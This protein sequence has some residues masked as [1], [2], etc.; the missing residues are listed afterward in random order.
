MQRILGPLELTGRLDL[1]ISARTAGI[2]KP[3]RDFFEAA[4]TQARVTADEAVMVGDQYEIDIIGARN[5]G[6]PAV[7][8]D[9]VGAFPE[10]RDCPVIRDLGALTAH[11]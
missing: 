10:V 11:L 2:G 4:L 3:H 6:I 7:L 9:R 5:A 8:L 1:V